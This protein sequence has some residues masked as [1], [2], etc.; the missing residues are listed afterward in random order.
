M[1]RDSPETD[2]ADI[3]TD[4]ARS[5]AF[6]LDAHGKGLLGQRSEEEKQLKITARR[7]R[8][9]Q[10]SRK[11]LIN[12]DHPWPRGNKSLIKKGQKRLSR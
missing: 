2:S 12:L 7:F 10:H 11:N 5:G 6:R 1:R 9:K 4:S 3:I 8:T